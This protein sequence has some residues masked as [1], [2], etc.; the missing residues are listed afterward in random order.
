MTRLEP[1]GF[2]D[3]D[4]RYL[5]QERIATGGMGVVWRAEDTVLGRPVAIKVL[6]PEYADDIHFRTRFSTE[7]RH[8]GALHHP[9]IASVFD[10]GH[11]APAD[12]SSAPRPY[13]VME[14]V[15]GQPLSA[16]LQP[17][18]PMDPEVA[19]DLLIQAAD[20]LGAAH[21]QGIVH[22]D[23]KPANLLVTPSRQVK[24]TDFGIARAAES[25]ALTGTGQV[26]G[27]P[28]YLSPEQAQGDSATAASDVYGLG[29][30][31]Y[32]LLVGS[33]PF[34]GETAV[35]TA[36][37]HIRQPVPAL[38]RHVPAA[39]AA[40]VTRALAKEPG[41]RF[42]DGAAF[43]AALRDASLAVSDD[44]TAVLTAP[45]AAAPVPAA[46]ADTTTMP[47][48]QPATSESRTSRGVPWPLVAGIVAVLLALLFAVWLNGRDGEPESPPSDQDTSQTPTDTADPEQPDEADPSESPSE[49]PT[50]TPS[51]PEPETVE[52]VEEDW[53]GQDRNDVAQA[54]RDLG[55]VVDLVEVDNPGGFEMGVVAGVAP[56]GTLA[57]GDTVTI[58]Y[59]GSPPTDE[60]PPEDNP[61]DTPED[62][63]EDSPEDGGD[64]Q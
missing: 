16:L 28:A 9:G 4:G 12:G 59:Y 27:T 7:A 13:L 45:V 35:A 22:R 25:V 23:V 26:L 49:T 14:L 34:Q 54:L 60:N 47:S 30:V 10:Y 19:R 1:G 29:V 43:A 55:L 39:L 44:P 42:A 46:P 17:G 31:A 8:A 50:E 15:D 36:I 63:P 37:A 61:P 52:L 38:P 56:T 3:D 24:I 20:A 33:R 40:T 11:A 18:R 58:S 2:A 41:E 48:V 6:K 57:E 32:E 62:S 5:L 53:I 51:E 64:Q 21:A